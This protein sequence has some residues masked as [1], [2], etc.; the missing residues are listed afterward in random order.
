MIAGK[1]T[2]VLALGS[3]NITNVSAS[4]FVTAILDQPSTLNPTPRLQIVKAGVGQIVRWQNAPL[5][6][7]PEQSAALPIGWTPVSGPV[8]FFEDGFEV[9]LRTEGKK[10]FFRL[11]SR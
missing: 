8:T 5:N 1:T 10:G 3:R 4:T 2:G 11:R 7:W 9:P 6:L